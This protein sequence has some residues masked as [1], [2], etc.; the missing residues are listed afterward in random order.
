MFVQSDCTVEAETLYFQ[1]LMRQAAGTVKRVSM[2]LGG[3]AP[4]IVFD[5]ANVEAAVSGAMASKYR[6]SGQVRCEFYLETPRTPF[7][8][9][10]KEHFWFVLFSDLFELV[11]F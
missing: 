10:R 2:E 3:N 1:I 4:F 9:V 11:E 7:F 8:K 5:S 6:C